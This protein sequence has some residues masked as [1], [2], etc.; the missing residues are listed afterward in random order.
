M[1]TSLK[2]KICAGIAAA[3]IVLGGGYYYFHTRTD[4]PDV[5][6]KATANSIEKHDL[7]EFHR[8]VNVDSLLNSGYTGF[9]DGLTAFDN[10]MTPDARE[11]VKNF[12][13]M[14]REPMIITLKAALD[15]YVATG[16]L[17]AKKNAGVPEMLQRTGLNNIEVRGVKN[18]QLSDADR[19]EAFADLMIFQPELGREFPIQLVLNRTE[20]KN[21]QITRVQNFQEYVAQIIQARQS[22]LGDYLAKASEINSRHDTIIRE[23]EQKYG[24][25][26]SLGSLGQEQTRDNLKTL[27]GDVIKPDWEARKQELAALPI[28]KD[29]EVLH[30]LYMQIC[31]LSVAYA[32]DYETWL[33]DKNT[34]T[35]K[36]AE[37]KLH[38]AQALTTEAASI[39]KR[40]TE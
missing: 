20:D 30:N 7:K 40:M 27:F 21:W 9:V 12:T 10:S 26:L 38:Q 2:A 11:A 4:A 39:A 3:V 8:A 37:D 15:S 29:A 33:E 19:N 18:V 6:I 16:D 14:L 34:E 22:Q 32:Q 1:N 25:I 28:P 17:N 24:S 5:A 35:I 31:D 13:Q 23:A 36:A